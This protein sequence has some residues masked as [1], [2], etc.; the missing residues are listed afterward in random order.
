MSKKYISI[1]N[2]NNQ[3]LYLKDQEARE[4]LDEKLNI[5]D[6]QDYIYSTEVAAAISEK[7]VSMSIDPTTGMVSLVLDDGNEEV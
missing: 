5:S 7:I 4:A 1:I 2:K 3:S 6:V